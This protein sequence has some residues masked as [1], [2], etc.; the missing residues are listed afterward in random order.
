MSLKPQTSFSASQTSIIEVSYDIKAI[1]GF[2]KCPKI[3]K[4]VKI[5]DDRKCKFCW[6]MAGTLILLLCSKLECISLS[7]GV[8]HLHRV[9]K[10]LK[11]SHFTSSKQRL[12]YLTTYYLVPT[13]LNFRAKLFNIL[14]IAC[15]IKSHH[16]T[17]STLSN[18]KN[19]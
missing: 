18:T 4:N 1:Y 7:K 19:G 11:M 16:S 2:Y 12:R 5:H 6:E 17:S 14:F 15:S 3:E 10:S 9:Y 13:C 8:E